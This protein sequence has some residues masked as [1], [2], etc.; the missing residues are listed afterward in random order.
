[1]DNHR[2]LVYLCNIVTDFID[3]FQKQINHF[4]HNIRRILWLRHWV[5]ILSSF[6]WF[7]K[8]LKQN[9]SLVLRMKRSKLRNRHFN[10]LVK[11]VLWIVFLT[12]HL[13]NLSVNF[14]QLIK[15]ILWDWLYHIRLLL[16]NIIIVK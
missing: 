2:I 3:F 11:I 15:F 8:E 6:H 10:N 5:E 9:F 13:A 1:V 4:S 7:F 16:I 14:L 12:N